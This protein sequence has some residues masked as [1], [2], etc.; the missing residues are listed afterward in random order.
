MRSLV[1]YVNIL[2]MRILRQILLIVLITSFFGCFSSTPKNEKPTN[3]T[4]GI[5]TGKIIDRA[6]FA[7]GGSV[8]ILPFKAG[9]QATANPQLDR[10]ALMIAKGVIDY[11]NEQRTPYRV[12]TT[13]DQGNPDMIIDGYIQDFKRPGTISR[14]VF[15]DKGTR[16]SVSG[17][18][19]L[20][21][22]K[23]RVMVFQTAKTMVDPKKDGL[24]VAYQTGQDLGRFIVDALGDE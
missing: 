24:D 21:K 15:R 17:Q 10:I 16:L 4:L 12:L 18:M 13:Q 6:T 1:W 2:T 14:W 22:T 20:A 8:A 5:P 9:E 23:E 3:F 19:T 7:K 11:L